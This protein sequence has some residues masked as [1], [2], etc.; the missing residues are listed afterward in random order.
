[1]FIDKP[2][3]NLAMDVYNNFKHWR[4]PEVEDPLLHCFGLLMFACASWSHKHHISSSE[5]GSGSVL[6]SEILSSL[7]LG[8]TLLGEGYV[9]L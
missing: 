7:F 2:V 4:N 5:L 6:L 8:L 1:M 3:P 9:P